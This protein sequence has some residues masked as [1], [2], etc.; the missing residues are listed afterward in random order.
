MEDPAARSALWR[1]HIKVVGST[2]AK[3]P[4]QKAFLE[5]A[6]SFLDPKFFALVDRASSLGLTERAFTQTDEGRPYLEFARQIPVLFSRDE[7]RKLFL[8]VGD[9]ASITDFSCD[10]SGSKK[11]FGPG[12]N[13]QELNVENCTCTGSFC[14]MCPEGFDCRLQ[15]PSEPCNQVGGCGCLGIWTCTAV[16]TQAPP[17]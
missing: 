5:Y 15:F 10:G 6:D 4:Q 1:D 2:I 8:T 7:I 17:N 12:T 16:C 9:T 11:N 13:E 3:N 14:A